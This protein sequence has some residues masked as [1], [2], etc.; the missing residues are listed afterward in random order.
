MGFVGDGGN[1]AVAT[2]LLPSFVY[3]IENIKQFLDFLY[4][5]FYACL[6]LLF[7]DE[8]TNPG[9]RRSVPDV[10]KYSAVFIV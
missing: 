7:L 9:R 6:R 1:V 8:E 4:L 2:A 3:C 10:C 5:I